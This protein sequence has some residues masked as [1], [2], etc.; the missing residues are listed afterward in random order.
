MQPALDIPVFDVFGDSA[1]MMLTLLVFLAG[2]TLAFS[3]MAVL[4]VRG[5]IKRRAAGIRTGGLD[6]EGDG[7]RSIRGS[8]MKAAQRIIDYTTRHYAAGDGKDMKILRQRLV[9]AGI[10]DSSAVA[11]FFLGRTSLA[12]GLALAAFFFSPFESGSSS[13]WMMV[14]AA[15]TFGYVGPSVYLDRRIA[16]RR[17]EH[18]AGFPDF[19]DL[20]VVCADAGLSMEA[21]LDRVG[22]ELGDSY[23]SLT[24]NIHI[25]TLEIRA[26][27]PL[28]EALDHLADRLGLE[29]ARSF[30]TLIQQS[31]ELG[32]SITE[33]LR[34]YSD[35]MRHKRL[36]SAEEK[37]YS[38]PT[39]LSLPMMMC[40][41]PVLFVVILLPVAVRI[42]TGNY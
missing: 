7:V 8:S 10:F 22:R 12:V 16:A 41:F 1:S 13:Y 30:A 40:I 15:G 4:R 31:D 21:A 27:R 42:Y 38:L 23:P 32:S 34:V 18:R 3:I 37:A 19:M 26:G 35:D 28:T 14:G 6:S 33:A 29:E 9:R 20:L 24:A 36:S 25:A 11:Y 2:T 39:R 17:D 5:S